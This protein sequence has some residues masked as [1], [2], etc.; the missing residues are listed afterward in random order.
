MFLGV[1]FDDDD[2]DADGI[3]KTHHSPSTFRRVGFGFVSNRRK[4]SMPDVRRPFPHPP[5]PSHFV[6]FPVPM[7]LKLKHA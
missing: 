7:N 1:V 2:D 5:A 6:L 4:P 3:P